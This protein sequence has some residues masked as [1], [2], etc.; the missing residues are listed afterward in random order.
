MDFH[1]TVCAFNPKDRSS[2]LVFRLVF[3][4]IVCNVIWVASMFHVQYASGSGSVVAACVYCFMLT[5][6]MTFMFHIRLVICLFGNNLKTVRIFIIEP[7]WASKNGSVHDG[8]AFSNSF[9]QF[10][11]IK[12]LFEEA[13]GKTLAFCTI[14]DFLILVVVSYMFAMFFLIVRF[15]WIGLAEACVGFMLPFVIKN[16][17]LARACD[18]VAIEVLFYRLNC[19]QKLRFLLISSWILKCFLC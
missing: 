9:E 10:L 18:G 14:F 11:N 1:E 7:Y 2:S 3:E 12:E 5:V 16:I 19:L 4:S 17:M 13:Y 8:S 6:I 15:T